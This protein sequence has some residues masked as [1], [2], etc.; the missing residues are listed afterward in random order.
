MSSLDNIFLCNI[1][2]VVD[3]KKYGYNQIL[4]PFIKQLE[5]LKRDDIIV[6]ENALN[7]I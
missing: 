4:Q 5:E 7:I 2:Y 6:Y 3:V 1:H